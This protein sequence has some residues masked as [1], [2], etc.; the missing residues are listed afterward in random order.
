[1]GFNKAAGDQVS[2]A[3]FNKFASAAGLYAASSAGSDTYA[4]T[5]SPVPNDYDTGDTYF[6]KADVGNTGPA[7]LN[8]NSLGAK[9]LVK[10]VNTALSTGDIVAGQIVHV[11]YDGTNFQIISISYDT[12]LKSFFPTLQGLL[13]DN[14]L[15]TEAVVTDTTMRVS[16]FHL[17][18]GMT[19]NSIVIDAITVTVAGTFDISIYSEDGQT[20]HIA[21]TTAS[22]SA[23]GEVST[24]VASV[25]LPPGN[26]IFAFNPNSTANVSF[27]CFATLATPLTDPASNYVV[28]GTYTISAGA[29]PT[30]LTMSSIVTALRG[31]PMSL[32]LN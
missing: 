15:A 16:R 5:V 29:P 20:R 30:T 14:P 25:Y 3:E 9:S 6:F 10:Q 12:S 13:A 11:V 18:N 1:M 28:N 19:V 2:A 31:M 7:T 23:T 24:A 21:I 32:F 17:P 27:R 26:Y 8:V 4:I 22:I